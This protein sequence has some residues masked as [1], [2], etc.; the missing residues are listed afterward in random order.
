LTVLLRAVLVALFALITVT[1]IIRTAVVTSFVDQRPTVVANLWPAHP[2]VLKSLAMAD[3]GEAAGRG[4]PPGPQTLESVRQL[5]A[6]APLYAEPFLVHAALAQRAGDYQ[7]AE[8]LLVQARQR[9]PRS[10]AARYLLGDLY[11]RAG[12]IIP[13]LAEMSV[14]SRLLPGSATQLA[15][16]LAEFART[17]GS[18][19]EVRAILNDYPELEP[20]VLLELA[21]DHRNAELILALANRRSDPN[22]APAWQAK[23]IHQ[24]IE[25]GQYNEAYVTWA[26]IAGVEAGAGRGLYNSTFRTGDGPPPFNWALSSSGGGIAEPIGEGG[27]L[28]VL[29]YGREDLVLARQLLLLPPGSY[30][31]GMDVNGALANGS[32]LAWTLTCLPDKQ[33]LLNLPFDKN[34]ETHAVFGRFQIPAQSCIAQWLELTGKGQEFPKP[35]DF[36]ISGLQLNR[37]GG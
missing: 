12:R 25:E 31:L 17:S 30:G 32:S 20:A 2:K 35:A 18:V 16:A 3:V 7:R 11:L 5:A 22:G 6:T 13:A 26:K 24:L 1:Q 37:L 4:Q 9:D 21:E 27:G 29:Y 28:H 14:L 19:S 23:L 8:S 33:Q 36:R 10:R 15:P 34:S